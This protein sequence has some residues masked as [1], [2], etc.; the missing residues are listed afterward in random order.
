MTLRM[1]IGAALLLA[2]VTLAHAADQK[3]PIWEDYRIGAEDILS[4]SIT[5]HKRNFVFDLIF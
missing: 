1:L 4:I 3:A 2:V 5:K